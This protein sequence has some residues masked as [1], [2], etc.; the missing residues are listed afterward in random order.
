M[1]SVAITAKPDDF[2]LILG[3]PLYQLFRRAHLTDTHMEFLARRVVTLSLVAW[4][5]LMVL[6]MLEGNALGNHVRMPFLHDI[7]VHARLLIALPL[8][9]V[10]ELVVHQRMRVVVREFLN[11]G[12][13]PDEARLKF[14]AAIDSAM[15]LRNS[16]VAELL[17]FALVYL[18]GILVVWRSHGAL[19]TTA[20]YGT[21][22]DGKL[23]PSLAG[24]WFN[25]LSLPMVQFILLRWYY[26][27]FIWARFLWQVSGIEL[28]LQPLHPD[29]SGG[30]GFLTNITYA[31]AP[32]LMGQG[33]LLAGVMANR[34]FYA[35]ARLPDF[36]V[37]L[38]TLV[39]VVVFMVVAPVLVFTGM[40]ERCKR[41]GLIEYGALAQ[42]Y[43]REFDL[44]WLRGGAPTN[45]SLIGSS[46]IQSLA[47]LG[48]SY[49]VVKSM[50]WVPFTR[51][52]LVQLIIVT[53]LPTFPLLL[54]MIPLDEVLTRLFKAI[55]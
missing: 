11:R 44:K 8:F 40:L 54:T 47:D 31:F 23:H 20:W 16:I 43:V 22:A 35:G 29:R 51:E 5:P 52:T 24:W 25:C 30:L 12:L 41:K 10:A 21:K 2:S 15:R 4:L 3:G 1:P 6:S 55:F 37:E 48:N 36:K 39:T 53:L 46:D 50:K 18:V 27:I 34:I 7:D 32:L 13:L 49:E 26:R 17:L 14:D 45:E 9:I 38:F 19:E 28:K 42:R 33:V